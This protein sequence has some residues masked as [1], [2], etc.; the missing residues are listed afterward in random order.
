MEKKIAARNVN[1][2]AFL[3]EALDSVQE[4]ITIIDRALC[5]SRRKIAEAWREAADVDEECVRLGC[6]DGCFDDDQQNV[7]RQ[8]Q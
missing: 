6:V 8:S 7:Y 2:V 5:E 1:Q 4:G 3:L